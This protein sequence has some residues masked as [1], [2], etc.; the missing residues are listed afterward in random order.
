MARPHKQMPG[1]TYQ[2]FYNDNNS[3]IVHCTY[4]CPY[5]MQN[6]SAS[7]EAN[8]DAKDILERGGFFQPLQCDLCGKVSDVRFWQSNKL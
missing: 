6:A 3:L 2:I 4:M 1:R 8:T 5:C 7:F